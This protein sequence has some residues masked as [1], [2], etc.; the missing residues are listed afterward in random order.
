MMQTT[1]CG[2]VAAVLVE[3]SEEMWVKTTSKVPHR[4]A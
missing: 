4:I 3:A 1:R 2:I